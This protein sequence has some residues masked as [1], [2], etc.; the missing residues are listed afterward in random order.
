[1]SSKEI[2]ERLGVKSNGGGMW[3]IYTGNNVCEQIPTKE[4]W[5]KLQEILEF[6]YPYNK[7]S[8]TYN[9]ILGIND[10]WSDIKFYNNKNRIHPTQKPFELIE[11]LIL[12]SS[13]KNDI[14]L[15]PFMGSGS[16]ACMCKKNQREYVGFEIDANYYEKSL[17]LIEK[18]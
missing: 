12:A 5:D 18:F 2:N 14:I 11:R 13:N 4:L 1:M 8:Q 3:S 16:T 10:V 6:N 9:A 15:D 17:K 7:L